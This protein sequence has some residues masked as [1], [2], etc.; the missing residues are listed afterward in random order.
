MSDGPLIHPSKPEFGVC[1]GKETLTKNRC[2]LFSAG[3]HEAEVYRAPY[4]TDVPCETPDE[5]QVGRCTSVLDDARCGPTESTCGTRSPFYVNHDASCSLA[6]D[7]SAVNVRTTFPACSDGTNTQCVL[8]EAEC[9]PGERLDYA[10]WAA[11]WGPHPCHCE[12]VPTGVCYSVPGELM[13][14]NSTAIEELTEELTKENSFCAVSAEDCPS[15]HKWMSAREFLD[16]SLA[17]YKCQLCDEHLGKEDPNFPV[18]GCLISGFSSLTFD[19]ASFDS[20]ALEAIGCPPGT[21]FISAPKLK[22]AGLR[23]PM[24]RTKNWGTCSSSGDL[25]ECTNKAASCMFDFRFESDGSFCDIYGHKATGLSTQF[26]YCSP[27]TDQEDRDW[28][29]PRCVWS[30]Y[31]CDAAT[32]RWEEARLPDEPGGWFGGCFCEDVLTGVCKE[33]STGEYH[34]AVSPEACTDPASYVSQRNLEL[35]G[36]EKECRLCPPRPTDSP[37]GTPTVSPTMNPTPLPTLPPTPQPTE[38]RPTLPPIPW[39]TKTPTWPT[40][41]PKLSP[42]T[43]QQQD[44]STGA[45]AGIAIGGMVAC[46]LFVLIYHMCTGVGPKKPQPMEDYPLASTADVE[47]PKVSIT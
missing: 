21:E 15:D 45:I 22:E 8:D 26:S 10:K 20:C 9:L 32:E 17:T 23:C 11:E 27:R 19:A 3:C 43:S 44:L 12:D 13:D 25:V 39:P 34:C 1:L 6:F 40:E 24:Y 7:N 47:E 5:V 38:V 37:T 41:A 30:E 36:I 46:G 2:A 4:E 16:S 42:Q 14:E 18:G 29:N 31:E 33:P 28:M 35:M